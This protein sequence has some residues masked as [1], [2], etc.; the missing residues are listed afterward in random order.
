MA[1]P[2]FHQAGAGYRAQTRRTGERGF[3]LIELLVTLAVAVVLLSVSAPSLREMFNRNAVATSAQDFSSALSQ[4]RG[5][6]VANNTCTTLCAATVSA[7]GAP[8]CGTPAT[9]GYQRGW[10]LFLNRACDADQTD[11]TLAGAQL[12]QARNAGGAD[13]SIAPSDASLYR[14]MFDPRG[15]STAAVDGRF[16]VQSASSV[17]NAN[18]RT[19]CVDAAGRATV[20]RYT[21]SCN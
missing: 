6:A 21:T 18:S 17:S 14:L 13:I 15:I 9:G 3:T 5:L 19:I 10:I 7:S 11:P 16:Q 1:F 20:R 2:R 4:A 8:T 12:R